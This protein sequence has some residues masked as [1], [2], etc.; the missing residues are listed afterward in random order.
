MTN[1]KFRKKALLS[2]VAML[3]VA[4]VA[5][6]SATFAWFANNPTATATGL[7]MKTVA[8]SGLVVQS[9]SEYAAHNLKSSGSGANLENYT[10]ATKL[11]QVLVGDAPVGEAAD[12]RTIQDGSTFTLDPISLNYEATDA[13]IGSAYYQTSGASDTD[14]SAHED[15]TQPIS[16][17][18]TVSAEGGCTMIYAEKIYTR[19]T[20]ISAGAANAVLKTAKV[21]ITYNDDANTGYGNDLCKAVKVALLDTDG[22]I[23]GIW[24]VGDSMTYV[25]GTDYDAEGSTGTVNKYVA[26]SSVTK[27]YANGVSTPVLS[28][29][30]FNLTVTPGDTNSYVTVVVY[31]DGAHPACQSQYVFAAKD[32]ITSVVVTLNV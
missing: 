19:T 10:H 26:S 15:Y 5:L 24:G 9:E 32:L 29:T 18:K 13:D 21:D 11:N 22:K 2:S 31:L 23:I 1:T 17:F 16:T 12:T 6:G 14:G 28:S 3:L 27:F 8:D 4:L 7:V 20:D 25:K 30:D